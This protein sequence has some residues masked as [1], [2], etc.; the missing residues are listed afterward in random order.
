MAVIMDFRGD[1]D[2]DV[3]RF[4]RGE[5]KGVDRGLVAAYGAGCV[6]VVNDGELLNMSYTSCTASQ[7]SRFLPV[8]WGFSSE[9]PKGAEMLAYSLVSE[10]SNTSILGLSHSYLSSRFK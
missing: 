2:K 5:C 8:A 7:P 9:V 10:A 4:K 6:Y 3:L 1:A